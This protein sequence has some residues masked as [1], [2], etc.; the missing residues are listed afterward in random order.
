VA[1]DAGAVSEVLGDAGVLL[2]RK[3]PRHV[4]AVVSGLLA[5]PEE[6]DRLRKVGRA[7]VAALDVG[8]AGE[9]LFEAVRGVGVPT[10]TTP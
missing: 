3:Q 6:Q 10:T 2:D 9:R 8:G 7:R 4:A 5:D 1:Y